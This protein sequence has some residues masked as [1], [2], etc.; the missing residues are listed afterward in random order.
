MPSPPLVLDRV[1]GAGRTGRVWRARMT[2]SWQ[3]RD[4]GSFVAVKVLRSE[5]LGEVDVRAAF[6]AEVEAGR[7]V[8]HPALSR[9]VTS[10]TSHAPPVAGASDADEAQYPH[11]E[12]PWFAM[13]VVPGRS[14]EEEL[15][16]QGPGPEPTLRAIGRRVAGALAALHA[17]GWTHGDVKP[18]NIRFDAR[19]EAVLLDLGFARRVGAP[20]APLGTPA[21]LA[22][23][24]THGGPPS[25]AADVYAFGATLHRLATG[26]HAGAERDGT[27]DFA[28]RAAGALSPPS[29]LVPRLS[30]LLDEALLACLAPTPSAR[31]TA[32]ELVR[33]FT[34]GEA[35][36]WWR[37]RLSFGAEAR[38]DTAVWSGAHSLPLVG[39]SEVLERLHVA[40][41][42][43]RASGGRAVW[44]EGERG[45]GKSRVVSELANR[46]RRSDELPPLYLYGRCGELEDERPGA[47][48]LALL[49]R[50]LHLP[51]EA[52]PGP[53]EAELVHSLVAAAEGRTL[54]DALSS[55]DR[56]GGD[57]P[58]TEVAA[59]ATWLVRLTKHTPA[60]VFL[61]DI[62]L[63]GKATLDVIARVARDL[64]SVKLLLVLGVRGDTT[65]RNPQ[66][67]AALRA[68]LAD[69]EHIVLG[70][71]D[72]GAVLDLVE[73]T[74]HPSV[75]RRTLA[76][77]LLGRTGGNPGRIGELLRLAH[78]KGWTR[79]APD[80]SG[81]LEL[82]IAPGSLPR[83]ASF[84]RAVDARRATLPA[85]DQVWL[86]RLAVLG[87]RSTETHTARAFPRSARSVGGAL[88]RLTNAGW[89]VP[90]GDRF[91]FARP[92]DREEVRRG[93]SA[94]RRKRYHAAAARAFAGAT[95]AS[96][97]A[98]RRA[99]HLREAGQAELLLAELPPL[100]EHARDAG[101][102]RRRATLAGWGLEAL[103]AL[104]KTAAHTD[105]RRRLLETLADASDRIG[106]REDQR[107]ALEALAAL[108][109]DVE[110]DPGAAGRVY[111]LH[112]R[113]AVASGEGGLARGLVRNAIE[114]FMRA[115]DAAQGDLSGALLLAARVESDAGDLVGAHDRLALARAAAPDA[116][117][118]AQVLS[119][120]AELAALED[121]LESGLA[122]C[123][124][125]LELLGGAAD[126]V[127]TRG[128]RAQA[129][130]VQGRLL[131]LA[132]RPKRAWF[133]L[134]RASKLADQSGEVRVAVEVGA[135]RGRL[136]LDVDREEEAELE[137]REALLLAR[138]IEDRRGEALVSLFLATLLAERGDAEARGTLERSLRLAE[139][140]G[141][142]RVE[143]LGA[144]I[145][146]RVLRQ[147]SEF[148]AALAN[149]E[150][151]AA[152]VARF[153]AELPDRI[154]VDATHALV[155]RDLH[156][157]R[158]SRRLA[159]ELTTRVARENR[160]LADRVVRKRHRAATDALIRAA[161]SP[162]GPLYPRV[163]ITGLDV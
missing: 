104:P 138:T 147:S 29:T 102:P 71:L 161:L 64:A 52:S 137:L 101:H 135:R 157:R 16:L 6:T 7:A 68:R 62:D 42:L 43:T 49:H 136:M 40:W 110:R 69:R 146:A 148:E 129:H 125:A 149:V 122:S 57:T 25:P 132:G 31:P 50:W 100:L 150:H 151:A 76:R 22:P 41:Y 45:S 12:A 24:R 162:D 130:L 108:P 153:G 92:A 84:A 73:R 112:A 117:R 90:T 127:L 124:E 35:G 116:V 140:L 114:L 17:A 118:R 27:P 158:E 79:P 59:L 54:L 34:D 77:V 56:S 91:R 5:L 155:L 96:E 80:G 19:G 120:A 8:R 30:P 85:R 44:L 152:L 105:T 20:H 159:R 63:A 47:A 163:R 121:R 81:A 145:M 89:L 23:E 2:E 139:E 82:C 144:A 36:E 72:E 14:L 133:A 103:D 111:A 93:I 9:F 32:L 99:R 3:G 98:Y 15:Q 39:R 28:A 87:G 97:D 37:E 141:L 18:E 128:V 95:P 119:A 131:R 74:F 58:V 11:P 106:E 26:A 160:E 60:I 1:L 86:E 94:K 142:A 78:A 134:A 66:G 4:A 126:S 83:P 123:D 75:P 88:V 33:I 46:V 48:I 10:G 55:R 70:A 53:R 65:P 143:A 67:F 21:Y 13:E 61:D 115:G 156:R 107:Q 154:V 113:A 38:R 109:L 51:R